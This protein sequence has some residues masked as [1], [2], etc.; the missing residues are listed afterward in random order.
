[1]VT[2]FTLFDTA[3]GRCGIAWSE[4]GLVGVQ[5]PE[6]AEGDTRGRVLKR[7]PGAQE[8]RPSGEV[9]QATQAIVQLLRGRLSDLSAIVLDMQGVPAFHQKVY[10]AAR[11]IPPGQTLSYGDIARRVGSP[12]SARCSSWSSSTCATTRASSSG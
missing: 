9:R 6:A 10:Q 11:E 4:R 8:A 12:G 3:I 2:R 1:M 7:F 5:L